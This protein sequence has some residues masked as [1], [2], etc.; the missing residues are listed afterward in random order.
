MAHVTFSQDGPHIVIAHSMGT[1][2]NHDCP[3]RVPDCGRT[4]GLITFGS[5]LG[6]DEVQDKLHPEWTRENS[7]P[8]EKVAG[9]RVNIYDPADVA[10]GL[11]PRIANN[12][13]GRCG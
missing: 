3:R 9:R 1:V 6:I 2:I 8:A 13:R 10:S 5:P 4:D 12:F 7:S 11:D